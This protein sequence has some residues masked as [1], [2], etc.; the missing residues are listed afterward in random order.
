MSGKDERL[1]S[2]SQIHA[3][4]FE[5]RDEVRPADVESVRAI[6]RSSGFFSPDE[7]SVAVELVEERLKNGVLSG[8][9]FLFA[10]RDGRVVGYTCFGFIA[11]TMA[12]YDLYWIA[13]QDDL[14]GAGLGKILLGK[15]EE[16][17]VALGGKR[18]YVETSSRPA[19]EPTRVFYGRC[20]YRTEA[21]LKDFYAPGDDK[22]IFVKEV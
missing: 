13:V 6:V 21:V 10:E 22:V 9:R 11:C 12:S 20:G 19:Y 5:Y 7:I 14:R 18:V 1:L 4:P 15:S 8:Y 3:D 2:I 17:I 16:R